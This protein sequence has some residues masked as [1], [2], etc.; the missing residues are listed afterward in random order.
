MTDNYIEAAYDHECPDA[1]E[2]E[3]WYVCLVSSYQRYGG[4]EEG[5]WFQTISEVVKFKKFICKEQAEQAADKIRI[6]AKELTET[7][8]REYGE[9]CLRQLDWLEA[10]GLEAD[11]LPENDGETFFAVEVCNE[12]PIFDNSRM[13]YE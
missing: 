7:S 3:S 12:L 2:S 6:L 5:G 10:R 13:T 8:R 1:K 4:P 11:Y 9:H